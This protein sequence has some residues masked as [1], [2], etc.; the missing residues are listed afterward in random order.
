[1]HHA[2]GSIH[3]YVRLKSRTIRKVQHKNVFLGIFLTLVQIEYKEY[4][5]MLSKVERFQRSAKGA[6]EYVVQMMKPVV[7]LTNL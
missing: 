1:M 5:E 6:T 7:T 3:Y 2:I 4:F